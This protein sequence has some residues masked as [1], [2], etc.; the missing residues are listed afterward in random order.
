[1]TDQRTIAGVQAAAES[2]TMAELPSFLNGLYR[3]LTLATTTRPVDWQVR[4]KIGPFSF[5]QPCEG[6]PISFVELADRNVVEYR[7]RRR[8]LA[9]LAR[10]LHGRLLGR[11]AARGQA[12]ED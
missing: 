10:I 3:L 8:R 11:W 4:I 12:K 5:Y 2:Q 1:M 9:T 6:G 7:V